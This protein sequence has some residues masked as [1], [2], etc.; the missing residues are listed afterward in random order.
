MT[1][2]IMYIWVGAN[3]RK[4]SQVLLRLLAKQ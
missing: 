1:L 4:L 3:L 2:Q